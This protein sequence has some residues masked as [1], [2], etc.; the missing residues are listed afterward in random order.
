MSKVKLCRSITV[1]T[2]LVIPHPSYRI[3]SHTRAADHYSR[4]GDVIL[5]KKF[6]PRLHA[7]VR[8]LGNI[9]FK[10]VAKGTT[11]DDRTTH[12]KVR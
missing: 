5:P 9:P 2:I 6:G 3:I 8:K 7:L 12:L 4:S 10:A 1:A 11:A